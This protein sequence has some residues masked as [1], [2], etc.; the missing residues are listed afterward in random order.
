MASS[1]SRRAILLAALLL[2]TG[3]SSSAPARTDS[4]PVTLTIGL[5]QVRQLG[6]A[7]SLDILTQGLFVEPLTTFDQHGRSAPR[8][9]ERWARSDDGLTWRLTLRAGVTFQD[10]TPLTNAEVRDAIVRDAG[11]AGVRGYRVCLPDVVSAVPEG[12]RDIV[13][14]LS[15]P[16]AFLLDELYVDLRR[17]TPDGQEVGTGAYRVVARAQDE[18]TL[19]ANPH[20]HSGRPA[21][22]RVVLRAYDTLRSAWAEMMRGNVDFVWEVSPDAIEFLKDQSGTEVRTFLSFNCLSI[23]FNARRPALG[24]S[25]VR[26]ALS[27]AV[28]RAELV[29][30]GLKGHGTPADVPVWPNSWALD[31]ARPVAAS[32]PAE[33]RALLAGRPPVTFTCLLP[34]NLAV[35]E[36]LALLVQRQLRAV[37]VDMRLEAVP[38]PV[39]FQRIARGEFDAVLINPLGGPYAVNHYLLWHTPGAVRQFNVFGYSSA[40]VDAALEAMREARDDAGM[41]AA[42]AAFVAAM[43]DDPPAIFMAWPALA[44][45]VTR[46]FVIPAS[47]DGRD[48]LQLVPWWTLGG[49]EGR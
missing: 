28:D 20:Y 14:R 42:M 13:L 37:G 33:A 43:R 39:F 19:E 45:A 41:R 23:V 18:L 25:E 40:G 12:D 8:V 2:A 9:V 7:R 31:R 34:E 49:E 24:S 46:R 21:I 22:D 10:G 6:P 27:L 48:A 30:Q 11:A 4:R 16:C 5:P 17:T 47:A 3:C 29:Q 38:A 26:R 35:F 32:D 1:P 36:R 44:Q 15:R